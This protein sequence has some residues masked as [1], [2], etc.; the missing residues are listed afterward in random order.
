M[1]EQGEDGVAWA[2]SIGTALLEGAR[3]YFELDDDDLDVIVQAARSADGR[4]RALEILW[5]DKI[6]GGSGI[7]DAMVQEFQWRA[8]QCGT[9]KVTIARLPGAVY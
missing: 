2:W 1:E 8:L 9:L 5:V 7:I 6:L 4:S 3:R